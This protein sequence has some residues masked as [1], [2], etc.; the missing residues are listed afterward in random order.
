MVKSP[1]AGLFFRNMPVNPRSDKEKEEEDV[2]VEEDVEG[3]G[4]EDGDL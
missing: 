4:V 2:E 1:T 3:G